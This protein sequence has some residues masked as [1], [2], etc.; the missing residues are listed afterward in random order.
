[1]AIQLF[2]NPDQHVPVTI[3]R[4]TAA[5]QRFTRQ[6]PH[7]FPP[8]SIFL[9][10]VSGIDLELVDHLTPCSVIPDKKRVPEWPRT[11]DGHVVMR[12]HAGMVPAPD[13]DDSG[14]RSSR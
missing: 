8:L 5:S 2:D 14:H 10:P 4:F 13:I 12:M 7:H 9:D 1:M 11:H 3:Q 6:R